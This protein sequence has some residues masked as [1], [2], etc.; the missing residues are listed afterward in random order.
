MFRILLVAGLLFVVQ[1]AFAQIVHDSLLVEGHYRSFC[2]KKPGH[3][4]RDGSLV[5]AIHGS[6]GTAQDFMEYTE[7]ID[8][9]MAEDNFILVFPQGYKRY[10]N[11][12]R[13]ASTAEANLIDIDEEAFF[14]AMIDYFVKSYGLDR[15]KVFVSGVS[16]GGQM[17]YKMG[18][19][20]P[21][22]FLAIAAMV[23]NMPTADNMDC[24]A[25]GKPVATLIINGTADPVNPHKGGEMKAG[26]SLGHVVSTN[27]SF[28]YWANLAGYKGKPVKRILPDPVPDNDITME[29][30]TYRK[31]GK[32]EVTLIK[33]INGTHGQPEDLDFYTEVW[34]F[35]KRQLDGQ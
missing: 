34:D 12:C 15:Q 1:S 6:G 3:N 33:V 2:F 22:S 19:R 9:R 13:K 8:E 7:K 23:A 24:E 11:E 17:A 25:E 21:G 35:F 27:D 26:F 32:P 29:S 16:G 4:T 30:Y 18:M 10:W 28:Q 31:K 14:L 20:L 5:F